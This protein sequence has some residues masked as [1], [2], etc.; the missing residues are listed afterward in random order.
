MKNNIGGEEREYHNILWTPPQVTDGLR[1]RALF[2]LVPI[3]KW[4]FS[5]PPT[6][7]LISK[8]SNVWMPVPL[9]LS[10]VVNPATAGRLP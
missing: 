5:V 7:G 8:Y 1:I 4:L 10:G 9:Y 2:Y 6:A 3:H